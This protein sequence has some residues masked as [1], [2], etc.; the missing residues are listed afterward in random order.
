LFEK[1]DF[2]WKLFQVIVL[3]IQNLETRAKIGETATTVESN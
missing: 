2:I 3:Q 1:S